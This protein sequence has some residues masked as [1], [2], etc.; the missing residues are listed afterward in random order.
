VLKEI[1]LIEQIC[2]LMLTVRNATPLDGDAILLINEASQ[3][4]VARLDALELQRLRSLGAHVLV[5]QLGLDSLQGYLLAFTHEDRYDAEE[6]LALRQRLHCPFLYIDQVAI[7]P[8]FRRA[9]GGG[10]LY[11]AARG[12]ALALGLEKLCC[13]VNLNPPNPRSLA[14]HEHAGFSQ[15]GV[16]AVK[17]G[18][19]VMLLSRDASPTLHR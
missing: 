18:R 6:F 15:L 3:P 5:A 11:E 12:L 9:G 4:H 8:N 14:F 19:D 16:L 17:D 2:T 10:C 13:E 1:P 7:H